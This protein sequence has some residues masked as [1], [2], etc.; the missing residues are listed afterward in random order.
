MAGILATHY[1]LKQA[2]SQACWPPEG[3]QRSR[4]GLFDADSRE[5]NG[6]GTGLMFRP[7][8]APL[9]DQLNRLY[10]LGEER[11][12][13]LVFTVCC[14]GRMVGPRSL[15]EVVVV[16]LDGD[17]RQWEQR[18]IDRRLFCVEKKSYHQ[19][20]VNFTC[21]AYDMFKDNGNAGR[22]VQ[23]LN[24]EEWVVFGNGFDLCISS[25][26]RGLL[27]AGQKVC[28]L[29]D[30]YVQGARGYYVETAEG[31]CECGTTEN[32]DRLLAQFKDLGV[33]SL[34]LEELLASV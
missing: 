5:L 22:L 6:G 21:H 15:P 34:T 8:V 18:L 11:R 30:V 28:L 16:P 32:R 24:V 9:A 7:R 19:P 31:Q 25:A 2:Q 20:G 13:P 26:V 12:L 14:S 23:S 3:R 1:L 10:A 4:F 29:S 17:Q 27:A 33:R